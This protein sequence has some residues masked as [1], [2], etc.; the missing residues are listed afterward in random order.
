M[1]AADLDEMGSAGLPVGL[2]SCLAAMGHSTRN[3]LSALAAVVADSSDDPGHN[4]PAPKPIPSAAAGELRESVEACTQAAEML[5]LIR[6]GNVAARELGI[7]DFVPEMGRSRHSHATSL[8]AAVRR[9]RAGSSA[10]P[11][12]G[13]RAGQPPTAAAPSKPIQ[14]RGTQL[15]IEPVLDVHV[16][17]AKRSIRGGSARAHKRQL[18]DAGDER[19]GKRLKSCAEE[20]TGACEPAPRVVVHDSADEMESDS[21]FD[22]KGTLAVQMPRRHAQVW[23]IDSPLFSA[24]E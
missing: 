1:D 12:V 3:R 15:S 14:R 20:A 9:T 11:S 23:F 16:P 8:S 18:Q 6:K 5:S 4:H 17:R 24:P 21:D 13:D 10:P 2:F 22:I 7:I 19:K